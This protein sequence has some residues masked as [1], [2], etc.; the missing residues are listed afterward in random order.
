MSKKIIINIVII[1]S[2]LIIFSFI[3]LIYGMYLK[4]SNNSYNNSYSSEFISLNLKADEEIADIQ[5]IDANRLL[6]TIKNN[7]F[8]TG[9]IYNIKMKKIQEYIDK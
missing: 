2:I 4:I 1:L 5:V 8:I 6:I 9:A 3:A 7:T